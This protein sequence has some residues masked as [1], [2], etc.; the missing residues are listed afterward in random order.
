MGIVQR[1]M[2]KLKNDSTAITALKKAESVIEIAFKKYCLSS[3]AQEARVPYDLDKVLVAFNGG[4]DCTLMLYLILKKAK[5]L[6]NV[7]GKLRLMY[8]REPKDETFP[9]IHDFVEETKRKFGL[10]SIEVDSGDLRGGLER[11]IRE[12]PEVSAIFMGTRWT[13]PNA[14]WM[15]YFCHTSPGWPQVDLVAPILRMSYSELWTNIH[16]L[17]VECCSLY[18][19]GYTSIG[20]ISDTVPNP[21]LRISDDQYLHADQLKDESLE[22]LGR[23]KK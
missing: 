2:D 7:K 14:G 22:R 20:S 8:I 3:S 17:G 21:A 19:R 4:K 15:D 1:D 10:E 11:I 16:Y 18:A 9:E 13:D 12:H 5:E 6:E 23:S